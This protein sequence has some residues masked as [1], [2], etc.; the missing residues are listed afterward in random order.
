M[1]GGL[2][3]K[4]TYK[5]LHAFCLSLHGF[6]SFQDQLV[7]FNFGYGFCDFLLNRVDGG[8]DKGDFRCDFDAQRVEVS[9]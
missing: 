9:L 6:C 4:S 7:R 1:G 3:S 5:G 8:F 2:I